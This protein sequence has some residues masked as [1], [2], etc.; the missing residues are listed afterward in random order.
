MIEFENTIKIKRP[1]NEVFA[2]ISN[3]ENIPKWN[4]YVLEVKKIT[5]GSIKVGTTFH[6]IR[7]IDNQY[8]EII[9]YEAGRRVSIQTLPNSSPAFEMIF[10]FNPVENGTQLVDKWKLN[11]GKPGLIE[12]LAKMKVKKAVRQNLTKLKELLENGSVKLQ[13]GRLA[14]I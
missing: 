6:Q 3:F 2:F 13:D 1:I 14:Q 5:E 10:S 8:F 4:Y 12:K 11:S 9:E 7:K